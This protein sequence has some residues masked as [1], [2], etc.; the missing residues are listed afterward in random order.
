MTVPSD[1]LA[2]MS[3]SARSIFLNPSLWLGFSIFSLFAFSTVTLKQQP[4]VARPLIAPP[5]GL[6]YFSFGMKEQVGDT[7]W[8]RALQDMEY[9]E[10]K[11]DKMNCAGEGWLYHML[12]TITTLSPSFRIVYAVGGLAL[13][14]MVSDIQGASKFYDKATAAFPKDWS[15]LYAAAYHAILEEKDKPKGARLLIEVEKNG[16]PPWVVGLAGRL[17]TESG[18]L[19]LAEKLIEDLEAKKADPGFIDRIK[20]RI[21]E[22]KKQRGN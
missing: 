8:I 6:E 21:A 9:C 12:D 16:G 15:I 19:D 17:Y 1:I 5:K 20:R 3:I 4:E 13:T 18:H 2:S 22:L 7:L 10:E 11:V 14:I